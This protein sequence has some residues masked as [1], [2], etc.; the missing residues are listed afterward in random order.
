[1]A[2]V[3]IGKIEKFVQ[4]NVYD[5]V[6][7]DLPDGISVEEYLNSLDEYDETM[8]SIRYEQDTVKE[9]Q[10]NEEESFYVIDEN[11]NETSYI[12]NKEGNIVKDE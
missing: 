2:K 6:E 7:V 9:K 3:K 5:T 8:E 10:L 1:M 4:Y 11:N 12:Y